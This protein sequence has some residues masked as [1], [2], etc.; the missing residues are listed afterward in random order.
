MEVLDI[1]FQE[2]GTESHNFCIHLDCSNR[3]K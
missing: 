1:L 2:K 3:E